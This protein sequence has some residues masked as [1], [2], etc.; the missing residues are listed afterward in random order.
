M[1][2]ER[3]EL[4][5]NIDAVLDKPLIALSFVWLIL[6]V[7]EL[8]RGISGP[9]LTISYVIWG[10][11]VFDF[12]IGL[13]IAPRWQTYLR[14]NWLTAVS[15]LLP[16]L[17]IFRIFRFVRLLRAARTVR[18]LSLARVLTTINRG[19]RAAR[20]TLGRR[21]L[22]FVVLLTVIVTI[23][24]A[25]GMLFFESTDALRAEGVN[26]V[27][28]FQSYGDALW[29]TAMIMTTIGSQYWPVTA[30][31]RIL[32]VLLSLYAVGVFGYVTAAIASIFIGRDVRATLQ[33]GE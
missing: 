23:V 27:D 6:I 8:T 12:V 14:R 21:A 18:S 30:E 5:E 31:G 10:I 11:F 26:D 25:A 32:A 19:M 13:I 2:K 17:R 33:S 9:F 15:L 16:A 1:E 24:G 20:A 28:G 29:W 4:L 3:W 22:G 7:L